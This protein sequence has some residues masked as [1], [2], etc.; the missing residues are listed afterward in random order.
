MCKLL[1]DSAATTINDDSLS[2]RSITKVFFTIQGTA[3]SCN[4]LNYERVPHQIENI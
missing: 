3:D 2:L 1:F 4:A